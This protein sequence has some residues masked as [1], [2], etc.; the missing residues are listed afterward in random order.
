M[1]APLPDNEA[2]RLEALRRYD[3]LDT[4]PEQAYD[5]FTQL[6]SYI[7]QTPIALIS[8]VDSERQWFKSRVGLGATETHRDLSFCAHAILQSGVFVVRNVLEDERFADNALVT[9]DPHIRFYAGAPLVTPEGHKL[10]TLCAI[11]RIPRDFNAEQEESLRALSRQ[12]MTQL[13]LRKT[14]AE[15]KTLRG[16][17]PICTYCKHIRDDQNYWQQ[18]ESYITEHTEAQFSHSICPDCFESVVK[19]MMEKHSA[20]K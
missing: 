7:C 1:K 16:I 3:I 20:Q 15:L 6:A 8:L 13:E 12:V 9:S 11:D 5:D 10:G 18:V 4:S 17:L 19:P 14:V 2:K